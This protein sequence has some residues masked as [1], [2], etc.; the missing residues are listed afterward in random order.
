M[1][2]QLADPAG[3][4]IH[5][6]DVVSLPEEDLL[7]VGGE[8]ER[9]TPFGHHRELRFVLVV[10]GDGREAA[11]TP[12]AHVAVREEEG[13]AVHRQVPVVP[14]AYR[15]LLHPGHEPV[16]LDHRWARGARFPNPIR[17]RTPPARPSVPALLRRV[18]R[19]GSARRRA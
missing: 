18:P 16:Q 2:V 17:H 6:V 10:D 1:V 3:P 19:R 9:P 8:F 5:H 11:P 12:L 15:D 14:G 4:G 13:C 7:P